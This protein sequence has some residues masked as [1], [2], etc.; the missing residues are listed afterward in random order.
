LLWTG[1]T[2]ARGTKF[3]SVAV[4]GN[5]LYI[6][7]RD[8]PVN[9]GGS[10]HIYGY[11]LS[12]VPDLSE[13]PYWFGD[14]ALNAPSTLTQTLTVRSNHAIKIIG[15]SSGDSHFAVGTRTP[16]D[17]TSLAPAA[18]VQVPVTFT[19][20]A[21][22]DVRSTISLTID[23][24]TTV[25]IGVGGTGLSAPPK[26]T[27]SPAALDF[28]NHATGTSTANSFALGNSGSQPLT[29]TTTSLSGNARN[30]Y[31]LQNAPA[32]PT[33]IQPGGSVPVQVVYAPAQP[34][35]G[36]PDTATITVNSTNGGSVTV[37]ITGTA[38]PPGILSVSPLSL[39][40]GNVPVG[41]SRVLHFTVAN[42]GGT[43]ISLSRSKPPGGDFTALTNL[44]ESSTINPG[45]SV[46][47]DV[48]FAPSAAGPQSA[49][50][51]F[52]SDGQGGQQNVT[53]TGNGIGAPA[54]PPGPGPLPQIGP[55]Y[56]LA[57]SDGGIFT[58]GG[59]GFFGSTGG[60]QLNQPIVAMAPTPD[61]RGYWLVA[62]DGGVFC[63]GDAGF[64]GS[65]GSIRLNKPIVG[66]APA[67]DGRGYWLVASD[68]GIFAFGSAG[69]FGST[70]GQRLNQPIVG[71]AAT[72]DGGGYWL[73]ASDG[74]IFTF[75]NAGFF[76]STGSIHLFRPIAGM[77]ATP[78]GGGYWLVASDGGIF[79]FGHAGFFGSTGG[80]VL[81]QPVLGMAPAADGLG[82]WLVAADGGVFCFGDAPFL[83]STG[84]QRLNRPVV[85]MGA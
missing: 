57:A 46:G 15:A 79:A 49:V 23:D 11:W 85:G 69:F 56:W 77:A 16:S 61:H 17:G 9:Q 34:T 37:D 54:P 2:L 28:G 5:H 83:G 80:T 36:T 8:N 55:G 31:S 6:G 72:H 82:Y 64:F 73:V 44:P 7:T 47:V 66:M 26:L 21:T 70:G 40:A 51:S 42:T 67:P 76:G 1:P 4:D 12:S 63:F 24:G 10:S 52:N 43:T 81:N 29:V 39:D 30:A 58:F 32:N 45:A 74:G 78:D 75:G 14:R 38:T 71:M 27:A 53:F 84:G 25:S 59:A 18:T 48:Q 19:P 41:Q 65:T 20:T 3:T 60:Q 33:T 13:T 22:G 68:G 35:N 50:W 62:S